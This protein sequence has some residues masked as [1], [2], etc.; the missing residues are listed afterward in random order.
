MGGQLRV[1]T[2]RPEIR[3][4]FEV[5]ML[6]QL[7]DID[8]SRDEALAATTLS[9]VTDGRLDRVVHRQH[10]STEAI[11]STRRIPGSL[12]DE[13]DVSACRLRCSRGRDEGSHGRGVEKRAS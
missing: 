6:D 11:S 3:R 10:H 4:I 5:T 1:V 13:R 12:R 2:P 7:F 9:G 8:S